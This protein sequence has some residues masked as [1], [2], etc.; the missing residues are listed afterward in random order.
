MITDEELG[1]YSIYGGFL[2]MALIL[3]YHYTTAP[4]SSLARA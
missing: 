2:V 4:K 3:L 1:T